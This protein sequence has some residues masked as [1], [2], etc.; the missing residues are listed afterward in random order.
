MDAVCSGKARKQET[1]HNPSRRRR[2]ADIG[3]AG[4]VPHG[5]SYSFMN[6]FEHSSRIMLAPIPEWRDLSTFE[7]RCF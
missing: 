7:V 6:L 3:A 2:R 5:F 4:V 1:A